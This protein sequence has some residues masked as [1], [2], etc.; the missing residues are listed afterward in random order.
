MRTEEMI[1]TR[2]QDYAPAPYLIPDVALTVRFGETETYIKAT[3]QIERALQTAPHTPLI[4]DGDELNLSTL[5]LNGQRL[6]SDEYRADPERLEILTPPADRFQLDIETRLNPDQN[7][8]LSGLYRSNG[9]FCTQCEAEGFRRITY[10]LDRPDI[11]S[12]YTVRLEGDLAT[13]PVLLSNGNPGDSGPLDAGRHF[14]I[15]HDPHP[16]PAYLFAMVAGD[17]DKRSDSFTT[18]DG[19]KVDL[20][21]YVEHGKAPLAS[22]AMDALKRSM[23]WDEEAFGCIYD[24]D[25]FNI[26]AVSDF[27]MGAM[28][29]KG[30]NI[31][32]DR[33]ILAD[34]DLATDTDYARIEAIVA[35]EYFHNWTGNRITCRDW[36]Q[37]CLKE[38]LTVYRDHA[39]SAHERDASVERI[40]NV[41]LLKSAQFA[42]DGGPLAHPVRP[43]SYVEIN[44]FYTAT[45]YEKGAEIVRMLATLL[46]PAGFKRGM[47]HYLSHFDGTAATVEDF[48]G[49]FEVACNRDL[50]AFFLWYRQAGTPTLSVTETYDEQTEQLTLHL[51]QSTPPTPG[52]TEKRA[53]PIPVRFGVISKSGAPLPATR[54]AGLRIDGIKI[55]D[56]VMLVEAAEHTVTLSGLSE[57]PLLSLLRGFSAP[58]LLNR[59]VT[60]EEQLGI[61]RH[62][63]DPYCRWQAAQDLCFELVKEEIADGLLS[64]KERET[65]QEAFAKGLVSCAQDPALVPSFRALLLALPS[66]ADL[67]QRIGTNI[68]PDAIY[69]ARESLASRIARRGQI[70]FRSLYDDL[71]ASLSGPY[72]PEAKDA[73][74]R[75]LRLELLSSLLKASTT[76]YADLAADHF[77]SA[78]NMTDRFGALKLLVHANLPVANTA[79]SAFEER[80]Q[81]SPLAMDKWLTIHATNPASGTV[82]TVKRLTM[83]PA[84]SFDNPNRVRALISAFATANTTEFNRADGAGY[85][86]VANVVLQL[87]RLN[88]QLAARLLTA[89]RSWQNLEMIRRDQAY[90]ALKILIEER[91]LSRD[92]RDILDRTIAGA[93]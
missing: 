23:R 67:A 28:E 5:D 58:I 29:N 91:E 60:F 71:T 6:S 41:R 40:A 14:A 76:D 4:L 24:L 84:F 56:D 62:D 78:D 88:P 47:A 70:A 90:S 20:A 79:S 9:V 36:F 74:R 1:V 82:E 64:D 54:S 44:N 68:D 32:N 61:L 45:V 18:F 34:A 49:S 11:L 73:G 52:Q 57:K 50:S 38:G 13:C 72:C 39:F 26:V 30:L 22:Y 75:A 7:K 17:L 55:E 81:E 12:V 92:T 43:E 16:K 89:F 46:G 15:W 93:P 63:S 25:V 31:F 51:T 69:A 19:K 59:N 3:L 27:N 10:F 85:R 77:Q 48:V 80:Y 21:I 53:L 42:E 8:Q 87:D 86:F 37:L 33:Y 65:Q 83:H 35:H 66:L 2:L